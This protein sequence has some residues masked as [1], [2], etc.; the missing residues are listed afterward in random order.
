MPAGIGVVTAPDPHTAFRLAPER[1]AQLRD[2][3]LAHRDLLW[4][5][6]RDART[7]SGVVRRDHEGRSWLGRWLEHTPAAIPRVVTALTKRL[8]RQTEAV[9]SIARTNG[10]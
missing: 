2:A 8:Q 4:E 5:A 9:A 1:A 10:G 6:M 3:A 7:H